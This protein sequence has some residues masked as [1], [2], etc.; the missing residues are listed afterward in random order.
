MKQVLKIE[1]LKILTM[2]VFSMFFSTVYFTNLNAYDNV[3][4][5]YDSTYGQD[6]GGGA[7]S[8]NF[9]TETLVQSNFTHDTVTNNQRL[10]VDETATYKLSY[11]CTWNAKAGGTAASGRRIYENFI[12]ING[13]TD[14]NPSKS[15]VYIRGDQTGGQTGGHISSTSATLLVTLTDG[16]YVELRG[17][18]E[19]GNT[20]QTDS[21]NACFLTAQ[22]LNTRAIEVYDNTGGQ[23]LASLGASVVVNLDSTYYNGDVGL[24]SL[25]SDRVTVNETGW[26]KLSY[27][28]CVDETSGS[29]ISPQSWI[30]KNGVSNVSL[31]FSFAGYTRA[32]TAGRDKNCNRATTLINLSSADYLELQTGIYNTE[33]SPGLSLISGQSWMLIEK[34]EMDSS[35]VSIS[36]GGQQI[37]DGATTA[38]NINDNNKIGDYVSHSGSSSQISFDKSGLYEIAYNVGYQDDNGGR[39]ITCGTLRKNGATTLVPS[40]QCIYTRGDAQAKTG[41]VSSTSIIDVNKDDYIEI[42]INPTG[43]WVEPLVDR[44]WITITK[45]NESVKLSWDSATLDLGNTSILTG[46]LVG[47]ETFSIQGEGTQNVDT[48]CISG[49]CGVITDDWIDGTNL[50][51]TDLSKSVEFTCD[52]ATVGN[53]WTIFRINSTQDSVGT[54]INVSC[55]IN[56]SYGTLN[57]VLN[58]PTV[59]SQSNI[60]QN[61]TFVFNS[62]IS[63]VGSAGSICLNVTIS[64]KYN[65]TGST[66]TNIPTSSTTPLWTSSSV[67]QYCVLNQGESCEIIWTVNMTGAPNSSYK[68]NVNATSDSSLVPSVVSGDTTITVIIP[69]PDTISW[70]SSAKNI[71]SSGLNLGDIIGSSQIIPNGNHNNINIVCG[72]GDCSKI[73]DDW[74]DGT[75]LLDG[76]STDVTFTCDDSVVGGYFALFNVTSTSDTNPSVINVSCT[77]TQTFGTLNVTINTPTEG[78][79]TNANYLSN[80]NVQATVI[81]SGTLGASCGNVSGNL[82]YTEKSLNYGDGSDG[83]LT[84]GGSGTVVNTYT[85]LTGNELSADA[86][87]T[88]NSVVGFSIGDEVLIIQMQDGLASGVSGNYEF[89]M[90]ENIT[91]SVITLSSSL[92][93]SYG[94]GTF[95]S[96]PSSSTQVIRVPQYTNLTVS[97]AGSIVAP[98]WNG[99]TGGVVVLRAQNKVITDGYIDVSDLGFRGGDC[100]GCGNNAWGDQG[101]GTTGFG[102]TSTGNNENGGGG[103]DSGAVDGAP[104][105]GG[106]YGTSGGIGNDDSGSD[107]S[108]GIVEGDVQLNKMFLGGGAGAGG[109]NNGRTPLPQNVD[110][111]GIVM[112]FSYEISNAKI[113]ANGETGIYG[114]SGTLGGVSGSGAGGTIWLGGNYINI[115]DVNASGGPAINGYNGDIGGSGGDGRIRLDYLTKGGN[116]ETP[117]AGYNFSDF[118]KV[119]VPI[120]NNT[121]ALPFSVLGVNGFDCFGTLYQGA[122]CLLSWNI[123]VNSFIET[124]YD[125]NVNVSSELVS[126]EKESGNSTIQITVGAMQVDIDSPTNFEKLL[127]FGNIDFKFNISGLGSTA[128]NCTLYVDGVFETMEECIGDSLITISRPVAFGVHNWSVYANLTSGVNV[129]SSLMNFNYMGSK[130]LKTSKAISRVGVNIYNVEFET[131]NLINYSADVRISTLRPFEFNA[132]VASPLFDFTNLTSGF[133]TGELRGW[134]ALFGPYLVFNSNYPITNL[135]QGKVKDNF[136]VGLE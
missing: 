57:V 16:D 80:I 104:G 67:P 72:S 10:Y 56:P 30:R 101:E 76:V 96:R 92:T 3:A 95:N 42:M 112:I 25:A 103:G 94:S 81:C 105:G 24:Y 77:V 44:T 19:S 99:Q 49:D 136:V 38:V 50:I 74:T 116:N 131:E 7:I 84:V 118:G 79:T 55:I 109:D 28:S 68:L 43:G 119:F 87:I 132:G 33:G 20:A 45:I 13:I 127:G 126:S 90:I 117:V 85:Y 61:E 35:I 36:S 120:L 69:E 2:L 22:K 1:N 63:C 14:L 114:S 89:G 53:F 15:L 121:G 5:I 115:T 110:G 65:N 54:D 98:A 111:G 17:G 32:A 100:N 97:A 133:Y 113:L 78:I 60:I 40:K 64:P 70:D 59:G 9:D 88:V 58:N 122:N 4:Q 107:S 51:G 134:D 18:V 128:F 52:D 73:T 82:R 46:D 123:K 108:G 41:T 106:G 86:D 93:N 6:G 11:S 39:V 21:E 27:T 23:T 129:S 71:G 29:R 124:D 75:N 125:L 48:T 8:L 102:T 83:S 31:S 66:F 91:G 12:R 62:T 37:S 26:Y 130:H 34:I 135:G 47:S